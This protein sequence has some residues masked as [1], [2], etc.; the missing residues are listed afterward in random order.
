M[1]QNSAGA[2]RVSNGSAKPSKNISLS[3]DSGSYIAIFLYSY[4]TWLELE[5]IRKA[6]QR[7]TG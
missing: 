5:Q 1:L 6:L 2:E 7:E 3:P 4:V